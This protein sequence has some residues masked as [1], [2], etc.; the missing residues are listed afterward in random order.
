[1]KVN[2]ADGERILDEGEAAEYVRT[3]F[4][5]QFTNVPIQPIEQPKLQTLVKPVQPNEVQSA[6]K[7]LKNRRAVGL[8]GLCAELLKNGPVEMN[9]IIADLLIKAMANGEDLGLGIAKLVTVPK[10]DKPAGV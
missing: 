4:K 6:V 2:N 10:P 8:D 3:Y 7:K 9:S 1:M 5:E